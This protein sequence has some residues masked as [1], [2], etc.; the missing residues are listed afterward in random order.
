MRSPGSND[1]LIALYEEL[2]HQALNDATK[3]ARFGLGLSLF[4]Q[5]GMLAWIKNWSGYMG[6]VA[7]VELEQLNKTEELPSMPLDNE[8]V[9]I[10]VNMVLSHQE[11]GFHV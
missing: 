4:I 8:V 2:R 1:N 6:K 7:S 9:T 11:G 5:R 3:D 10:L